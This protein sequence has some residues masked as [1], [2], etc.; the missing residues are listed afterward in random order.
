MSDSFGTPWI[1]AHQAPVSIGFPRREYWSGLPFSSPGHHHDPRIKPNVSCMA[2][3]ILYH[4]ATREVTNNCFYNF[5]WSKI[6]KN[7]NIPWQVKIIKHLN[8]GV[9][10]YHFFGTLQ[11]F[12]CWLWLRYCY[13]GRGEQLGETLDLKYSLPVPLQKKS[14]MSSLKTD[15]S[16]CSL[17]FPGNLLL[18]HLYN[19]G[20]TQSYWGQFYAHVSC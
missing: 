13:S 20:I 18:P 17:P 10:R 16:L 14:A 1:V 5:K 8:C 15:K 3:L 9:Y 12:A 6:L 19:K 7:D 2:R 4:W 11:L